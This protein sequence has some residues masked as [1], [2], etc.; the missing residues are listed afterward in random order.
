MDYI[1]NIEYQS[2]RYFDWAVT[3]EPVEYHSL[4]RIHNPEGYATNATMSYGPF[5]FYNRRDHLGNNREVWRASYTWGSTTHAAATVQ[6][7]QYYPS[8]LLWKYNN[9]DNP[10]SQPYKYNGK[11]FVEMHGLDECC[12]MFRNYQPENNHV[13]KSILF[14]MEQRIIQHLT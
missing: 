9:G 8:G 5:Y 2:G 6:R 12:Y 10:G 1:G 3:F 13:L 14:N 4:Y 7:T 11:E